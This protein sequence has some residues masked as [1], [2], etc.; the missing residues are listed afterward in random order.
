[1]IYYKDNNINNYNSQQKFKWTLFHLLTYQMVNIALWKLLNC[2]QSVK[3]ENNFYVEL[4]ETLINR[5]S[6]KCIC[7][8]L[9]FS[10]V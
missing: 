9:I 3:F 5:P 2:L 8:G 4:K 1:M 7:C 6:I 10:L